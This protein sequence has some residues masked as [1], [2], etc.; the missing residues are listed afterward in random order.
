MIIYEEPGYNSLMDMV[1][2]GANWY[3]LSRNSETIPPFDPHRSANGKGEVGKTHLP[4][5]LDIAIGASACVEML[6]LGKHVIHAEIRGDSFHYLRSTGEV[7]LK[8]LG[9]GSR[10][11]EDYLQSGAWSQLSRER[12]VD[13]K[14]HFIAPEQTGRV[15]ATPDVRTGELFVAMYSNSWHVFVPVKANVQPPLDSHARNRER[16]PLLSELKEADEIA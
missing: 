8:N 6:H 1:N 15:Q 13:Y 3:C 7:R 5:F 16:V 11:V 12:G 14:L 10:S 9:A 4:T 2:F